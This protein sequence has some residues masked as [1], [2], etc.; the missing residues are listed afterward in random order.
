MCEN[1][2]LLARRRYPLR[3]NDIKNL[4]FVLSSHHQVYTNKAFFWATSAPPPVPLLGAAVTQGIAC[5]LPDKCINNEHFFP[6][7]WS[8]KAGR[9]KAAL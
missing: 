7:F 8:E 4:L 5:L 2:W 6:G 1:A 9:K 3:S